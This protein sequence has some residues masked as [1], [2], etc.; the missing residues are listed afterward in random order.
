VN[1]PNSKK[2]ERVSIEKLPTHELKIL[3]NQEYAEFLK[4][5]D[6]FGAKGSFQRAIHH[7]CNAKQDAHRNQD[8]D[9]LLIC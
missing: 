6:A 5:N 3:L 7:D 4:K 2:K 8:C 1:N 9:S